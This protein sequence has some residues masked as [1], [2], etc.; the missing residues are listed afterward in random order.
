M[1]NIFKMISNSTLEVFDSSNNIVSYAFV[2]NFSDKKEKDIVR[3]FLIINRA[4]LEKYESLYILFDSENNGKNEKHRISFSKEI[5][6]PFE[7]EQG[8]VLAFPLA[9][10][11]NQLS[12][13]KI[14]I[15]LN[16]L[17]DFLIP[18]NEIFNSLNEIN[19]FT[20]FGFDEELK[21]KICYQQ[22]NLTILDDAFELY[23]NNNEGKNFVG[24][25]AFIINLG[26][27]QTEKGI[28]LGNQILLLGYFEET[29][30]KFSKLSSVRD[31]A[32]N[33]KKKYKFD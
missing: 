17:P 4:I 30:G 9:Q 5:I 12:D 24:A 7:I 29:Q 20:W 26:I 14:F 10:I 22:N 19:E 6:S 11:L 32:D 8:N 2:L 28:N 23:F 3:P 27:Y 16:G 15:E 21:K 1:T 31:L 13:K 25:P 18:N 33:I